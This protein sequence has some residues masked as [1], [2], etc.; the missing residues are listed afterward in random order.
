[1]LQMSKLLKISTF[2]KVLTLAHLATTYPLNSHGNR[3]G[4]FI[5]SQLHKIM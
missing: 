2:T 1:M 5:F 3:K 4:V